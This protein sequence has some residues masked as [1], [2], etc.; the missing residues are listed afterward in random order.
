MYVNSCICILLSPPQPFTHP[1]GRHACWCVSVFVYQTHFS[2]SHHHH[3]RPFVAHRRPSPPIA[4]HPNPKMARTTRA[5]STTTRNTTQ[6]NTPPS[7]TRKRAISGAGA[8]PQRKKAK[9][10]VMVEQEPGGSKGKGG[11]RGGKKKG[12]KGAPARCVDRR[13]RTS[14][15]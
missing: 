14:T 2:H 7:K 15:Y 8:S 3:R 11:K 10:D 1:F 9:P 13:L 6:T 5:S 12:P 4:D